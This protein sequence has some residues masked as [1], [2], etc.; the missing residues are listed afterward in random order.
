MKLAQDL[1]KIEENLRKNPK[2]SEYTINKI[3]EYCKD[4]RGGKIGLEDVTKYSQ[5]SVGE[6]F[7]EYK[8]EL[9]NGN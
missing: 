1:D 9:E 8:I 3:L 5:T 7:K 4:F 2:T 6:M